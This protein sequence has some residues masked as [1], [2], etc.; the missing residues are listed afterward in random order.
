MHEDIILAVSL[1]AFVFLADGSQM[2]KRVKVA[3]GI[4][5]KTSECLVLADFAHGVLLHGAY[6]DD[7]AAPVDLVDNICEAVELSKT[8]G[9]EA[10]GLEGVRF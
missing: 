4:S 9:G 6:W 2:H 1:G 10:A 5:L 8:V 7:S 3:E